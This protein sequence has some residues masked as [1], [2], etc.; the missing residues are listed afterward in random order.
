METMMF[1]KFNIMSELGQ[2]AKRILTNAYLW[3][4]TQMQISLFMKYDNLPYVTK[5]I[6]H[7]KS[8]KCLLKGFYNNVHI[9]VYEI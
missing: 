4:L 3:V 8:S 5:I 1:L 6:W 2:T 9:L 7:W